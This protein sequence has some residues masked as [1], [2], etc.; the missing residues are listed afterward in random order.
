MHTLLHS[1][2]TPDNHAI[3]KLILNKETNLAAVVCDDFIIRIYDIDTRQLVRQF[4]GHTDSITDLVSLTIPPSGFPPSA[5]LRF[6]FFLAIRANTTQQPSS[7]AVAP[8][9]RSAHRLSFWRSRSLHSA[10]WSIPHSPPLPLVYSHF[11]TDG[12]FLADRFFCSCAPPW[13]RLVPRNSFFIRLVTNPKRQ[14]VLILFFSRRSVR[15]LVGLPLLQVIVILDYGMYLQ[16]HVLI[17]LNFIHL[18]LHYAFHQIV[19]FLQRHMLG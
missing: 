4:K 12:G 14:L 3:S 9:P 13:S 16:A 5:S 18:L 19:I 17:G 7:P 6:F 1:I 2:S 8:E 11:L 10:G 15:L